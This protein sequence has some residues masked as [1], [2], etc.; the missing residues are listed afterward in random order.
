MSSSTNTT[1]DA[2]GGPDSLPPAGASGNESGLAELI[3]LF[4]SLVDAQRLAC[5][6]LDIHFCRLLTLPPSNLS[7]LGSL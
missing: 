7:H 6:I 3:T 2:L 4:A 5:Q 1:G